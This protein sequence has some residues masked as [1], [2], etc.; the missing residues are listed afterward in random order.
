MIVVD[1]EVDILDF[2]VFNRWGEKVYD[3][4][5]GQ[6]NGMFRGEKQPISTFTY[7]IK[8]LTLEH[9]EVLESGNVTLV[10]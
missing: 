5:A 2:K 7:M 3:D 1:E 4:P 6:W 9:G 10:R 8:I